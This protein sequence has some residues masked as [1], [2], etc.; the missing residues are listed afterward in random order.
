MRRA[1]VEQTHQVE[2]GRVAESMPLQIFAQTVPQHVLP[3][4]RLELAH[5]DGRLLIDDRPVQ[6]PRFVEIRERLPDRVRSRGAIDLIRS[7]VM[8]Q[9]KSKLVIQL[10]EMTGSR[11]S[12]P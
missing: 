7:R 1:R 10:R 5:D 11:S 4:Q 2:P 6:L 9:Q 3:D 12:P 8:G